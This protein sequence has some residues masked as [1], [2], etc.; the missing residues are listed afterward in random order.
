MKYMTLSSYVTQI[1]RHGIWSLCWLLFNQLTQICS[2]ACMLP[3]VLH[4]CNTSLDKCHCLSE[5]QNFSHNTI[6]VTDLQEAA[7]GGRSL[8]VDDL[9]VG[10]ISS[11]S[12]VRMLLKLLWNF[13]VDQPNLIPLTCFLLSEQE[14]ICYH[15]FFCSIVRVCDF[16]VVVVCFCLE[17]ASC[18]LGVPLTD[19]VTHVSTV[20]FFCFSSILI[21]LPVSISIFFGFCSSFWSPSPEKQL[22]AVNCLGVLAMAEAMSCTELHNMAKAFALQNF[23]EVG[24]NILIT[25]WK[26][27]VCSYVIFTLANGGWMIDIINSNI[28]TAMWYV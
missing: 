24:R 7:A 5:T 12:A 10:V 23:P 27:F 11:S 6:K 20:F 26:Q 14:V 3:A 13:K 2:C 22:T 16:F 28:F 21:I 17:I 1:K 8:K 19:L 9:V 4:H 15:N 25:P 18:M